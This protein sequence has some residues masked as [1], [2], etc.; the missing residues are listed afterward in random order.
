MWTKFEEERS[1]CY[2]VIDWKWKGYQWMSPTCTNRPTLCKAM[3]P[4]FFEGGIINSLEFVW[5]YSEN[6]QNKE[7][8]GSKEYSPN[9]Y[10]L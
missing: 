9:A 1:R 3:S 6:T 7:F 10:C 5:S 8:A 4:F 2:W